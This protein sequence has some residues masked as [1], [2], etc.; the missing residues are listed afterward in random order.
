MREDQGLDMFFETL[1]KL[2]DNIKFNMESDVYDSLPFLNVLIIK[3]GIFLN[4]IF[5][6]VIN[7]RFFYSLIKRRILLFKNSG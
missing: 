6:I 1:N 2:D 4:L 3:F 5:Q 7:I